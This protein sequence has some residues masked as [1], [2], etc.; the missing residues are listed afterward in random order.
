MIEWCHNDHFN[1]QTTKR[2]RMGM[3]KASIP[4]SVECAIATLDLIHR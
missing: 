3:E 4:V 2:P 1:A